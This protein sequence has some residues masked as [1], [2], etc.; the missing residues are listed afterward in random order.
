MLHRERGKVNEAE[1][2]ELS[3][4]LCHEHASLSSAACKIQ[5]GEAGVV[6]PSSGTF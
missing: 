2:K 3:C 5:C 1:M 4:L 6:A